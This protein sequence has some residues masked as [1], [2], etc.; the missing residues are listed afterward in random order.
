MPS[1]LSAVDTGDILKPKRKAKEKPVCAICSHSRVLIPWASAP[2]ATFN[3]DVN[4]GESTEEDP[5]NREGQY[6]NSLRWEQISK[7]STDKQEMA[8]K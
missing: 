4:Q 2:E 3:Q 5:E 8:I 1:I 6:T 7:W